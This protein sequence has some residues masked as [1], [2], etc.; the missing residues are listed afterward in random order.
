IIINT[1]TAIMI[2]FIS[3]CASKFYQLNK[4]SPELNQRNDF[5][6]LL[7][8][9]YLDLSQKFVNQYNWKDADYFAQKGLQV[10]NGRNYFPDKP[11]MWHIEISQL[12]LISKARK[13]LMKLI[14]D[15]TITVI[16]E[17]L[18]RLI[19]LYDCWLSK[20]SKK[21]NQQE[22][23]GCKVEFFMIIEE[24]EK[25]KLDFKEE[26]IVKIKPISKA[27]EFQKYDI[28][29]DLNSNRINAKAREEVAKIIKYIDDAN[30][31]YSILIIGR[32]DMVGK[33]LYNE[34]LAR[35]RALVL[36]SIMIK[37]GVPIRMIK[38]RSFG[39]ASPLRVSKKNIQN[40]NN[41]QA[42]VY[43]MKGSKAINDFSLDYLENKIYRRN[44]MRTIK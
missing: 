15:K 41:R 10:L 36:R 38:I 21:W 43:V 25:M 4:K 42:S 19:M 3:S 20:K 29:F 35:E 6:G 1:I 18:S 14:N 34:A 2:I 39:Y 31:N 32:A 24:I 9:S 13:K 12:D 26:S 16:P 5:I 17:K 28:D 30:G 27:A 7:A 44:I 23:A 40:K 11:Q 8:K 33:K 22:S 37:N